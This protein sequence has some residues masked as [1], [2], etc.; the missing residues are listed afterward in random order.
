MHNNGRRGTFQICGGRGN[1]S[2]DIR[3][4]GGGYIQHGGRGSRRRRDARRL[5]MALTRAAEGGQEGNQ[6]PASH[7]NQ[8]SARNSNQVSFGHGNQ[9][10]AGYNI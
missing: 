7:I 2:N 5:Q 9:L 8:V 6:L 4:G 3:H 10:P 1:A